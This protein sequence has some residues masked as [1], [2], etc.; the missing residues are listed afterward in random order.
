[1]IN[2]EGGPLQ[3]VQDFIIHILMENDRAR[4]KLTWEAVGRGLSEFLCVGH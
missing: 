4:S 1:M 2:D 3:P